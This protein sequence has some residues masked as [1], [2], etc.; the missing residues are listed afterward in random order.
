MTPFGA[1]FFL[2]FIVLLKLKDISG[3]DDYWSD[4][5]DASKKCENQGRRQILFGW[6]YCSAC[7]NTNPPTTP[8]HTGTFLW[9]LGLVEG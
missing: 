9:A 2:P 8:T 4:N 6:S 7:L 5:F 3:T 1:L